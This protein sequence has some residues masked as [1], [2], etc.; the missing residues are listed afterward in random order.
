MS[1]PINRLHLRFGLWAA[2]L[3]L[4]L[5]LLPLGRHLLAQESATLIRLTDRGFEPAQAT[6]RV[7]DFV[8]VRN[9]R[10]V[11]QTLTAVRVFSLFLPAIQSSAPNAGAMGANEIDMTGDAAPDGEVINQ[12]V[13]SLASDSPGLEQTMATP[14]PPTLYLPAVQS[15]VLNADV[16]DTPESTIPDDA[17][18]N[19]AV[20][21]QD[22][23]LPGSA[24]PIFEQTLNPG[25]VHRFQVETVG[26]LDIFLVDET[27]T[28]AVLRVIAQDTPIDPTPTATGALTPTPTATAIAP[29]DTPTSTPTSVAPTDTATPTPTS[30]PSTDTPTPTSTIVA[31]TD[32]PTVTPT[33]TAVA[34]T[35][36]PTV[37]PTAVAGGPTNV[38]AAGSQIANDATW[39]AAG[40]PYLVTCSLTV[41]AGVTL[42]MQSGVIVKMGSIGGLTVNGGLAA[43]GTAGS[44]VYITSLKDD[45]VGG[46]SNNDGTATSP[47]PG[48]W[49]SIQANNT[50]RA[51]L[52]YTHLSFGGN[53]AP[54]IVTVSNASVS[55]TSSTIEYSARSGIQAS[56]ASSAVTISGSEIRNNNGHGVIVSGG[57]ATI[58][59]SLSI[60]NTGD[61]IHL[62]GVPVLALT[63]NRSESN[64]GYGFRIAL[65]VEVTPTITN[66]TANANGSYPFALTTTGSGQAIVGINTLAGNTG[67]SNQVDG[68]WIEGS[69]AGQLTPQ[70]GLAY[71]TSSA[72][73]DSFANPGWEQFALRV[74]AGSTLTLVPGTVIKFA[75]SSSSYGILLVEGQLQAVGSAEN[76]IV[77]TSLLDDAYSGDTNNDGTATSP[78]PGLWGGIWIINGGTANLQ[79][80]V[81]RYGGNYAY[82]SGS[83]MYY[84]SVRGAPA[85]VTVS[86]ASVSVT[87]STIEYSARSGIQGSG[88]SGL[89][90]TNNRII[91]N[92]AYG[93]AGS[94]SLQ[95]I[96]ENNYWGSDSGPAPYGSGNGINYRTCYDNIKRVTYICQYYVDADPWIGKPAFV[97]SQLGVDGTRRHQH[98]TADPVNTAN[99]NF[100]YNYTDLSIA[101]RGLPLSFARSYNSMAPEPGPLGWAWTHAWHVFL[102]ENTDASVTV[103]FGDGHGETWSWNGAAYAG[104]PGIHH[105]LVRNADTTFDL[106]L[107]DQT[108][109]HFAADGRLAWVEDKN[110]NRTTL[111][112]DAQNRLVTVAE[113]AGRSLTLSYTSPVSPTLVSAV[114]DS[115]GR[116]VQYTYDA[117]ADLVAVTDVM[118]RTTTMTYNAAH[119]LL[120]I[121]D[122]NQHTFV[123]NTYDD[124][125]RVTE[126]RDAA[127][128]LWL[129][130]YDEEL[131]KTIV[132]DPRGAKTA[133][134]YDSEWRLVKETDALNQSAQFA[135]DA[136][137]N[138]IQAVD[139]RGFTTTMSY[140][141]R[142]NL[143][144]ITDTLGFTTSMS[145]DA[146]N[147]LLTQRNARGY[148]TAFVYNANSN[149]VQ[150]RD[151]LGN[152]TTMAY[153]AHGQLLSVTDPLGNVMRF[154][155]DNL[156]YQS[157][158]TDTV[159]AVTTLVYDAAG[160][161]L[162]E[163]D[164][165][166]RTT[167][168]TYDSANR[169]LQ[170]AELLG[171]V[172]AFGYDVVGNRTVITDALGGVT[173]FVYDEK[174]RLVVSID[175]LGNAVTT[176]YDLVDNPIA[177]VNALNYTTTFQYDLLN[178]RTAAV[179]PLG[180]QTRYAYDAVGNRIRTT[181]ANNNV[182]SYAY[183]GLG[184]LVS[185]TDA[186]NGVVTYSYDAAGNR[187]AQTKADAVVITYSFDPNNRLVATSYPGGA[188]AYA[189]DAVGNRTAMTDTTGVTRYTYD[190]LDRMVVV[191]QPNG[192][193]TYTYDL[194]NNRTALTYP[195]GGTVAYTY[196]AAGRQLTVTDWDGRVTTYA[197]DAAG[198][199]AGMA[200]PNGVQTVSTYDNA[201]RML[202][203]V[204]TSPVS[205]VIASASYML[206][207]AGNRLSMTDL[208]GL[209]T[210][211]YDALHRLTGVT[212][213][214]GEQVTYA[215]DAM[216]NRLAMTSSVEGA[217][218]YTYDA[219][220]RLLSYSGLGGAVNLA[221]DANGNMTGKGGAAYTFDA[222]NR[223]TQVVSDTT[224]QF[225]YTGD[226]ERV[227]K[228]SGGTSITYLQDVAVALPVVLAETAGGQTAWYAYGSD[229]LTE[230]DRSGTAFFYHA[231][232]LG[233]TRTRSGEDAQQTDRYTYDVFGAIR[234]KIGNSQESFLF[235]GEQEDSDI[236]MMFLR[237]RYYDMDTG[238]F[239]AKDPLP[240]IQHDSQSINAY[241]Y[242]GNNPVR[243]TDPSG[244][245]Y[246][247]L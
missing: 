19:E 179:D 21:A 75:N 13:S 173:R 77:F 226:G 118:N 234:T 125:G 124:R 5:I 225:S 57:S 120:T 200:Y 58:V 68:F 92:A 218:T 206:D 62:A 60:S 114:T 16:T 70:P 66:N 48:D 3:S 220:D 74:G 61:G 129:F 115:T 137:F 20:M 95:V 32:T 194:N 219:G 45:T 151:A 103:T 235:T 31:P 42:T 192:T 214:D 107:K 97:K 11:A 162:S 139:R 102:T 110:G 204:H 59:N 104:L 18:L 123:N 233:S 165:L 85:I 210:Y 122:A 56:G 64:S 203:I 88:T 112:Y 7:G 143:L 94:N 55:V 27:G 99:G 6:V 178:R 156:G 247:A 83:S 149:P 79:Q 138:R 239:I 126:Q 187:T 52:N 65:S 96:A 101:T 105:T 242:A 69:F 35:D 10:T 166:G 108:R 175:P 228:V 109:Y 89:L 213:P 90:V 100:I 223:L 170:I 25:E 23:A 168:F 202:S 38:C 163:T 212:Y 180:N 154:G 197:Y 12:G 181:D 159:G 33:V 78:T 44:P 121:T 43:L 148:E 132:T 119:R 2:A 106:T 8:E 41:N 51:F 160:R 171:K 174:D 140:D 172:T 205:G 230:V 227:G 15:S 146:R 142:S 17:V 1:S 217:T 189:Y 182:T 147:N 169:L 80:V 198:R 73:L 184:R 161:K 155:Y 216:G 201:D 128:K 221:W 84:G 98:M 72:G 113:P 9:D 133:Y 136:S 231:D 135:Y 37:T 82:S 164:A 211:T 232:G 4:L 245:T 39:T 244:L 222:F 50:G 185:V 177:L 117:A 47:R 193:L 145:Y 130:A 190:A 240:A 237:A 29:T 116:S 26:Q 134:E 191:V 157:V 176:T 152:V 195:D 209:T 127:G 186:L 30:V 91:A 158:I 199:Q 22:V 183:D 241:I 67:V 238:R 150:Q 34:P 229:L 36:T 131:R 236:E 208:D 246:D 86:N 76:P 167:S 196:D 93:V 49:K 144:V 87:S 207:A 153:N 24:F 224:T 188:V 40:N 14:L 81:A 111:T 243:F 28:R 54:A 46:D 63:D 141:V 71:V 215:Y 53:G